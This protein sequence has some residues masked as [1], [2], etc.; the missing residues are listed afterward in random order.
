MSW[1]KQRSAA[2]NKLKKLKKNRKNNVRKNMK[3]NRNSRHTNKGNYASRHAGLKN[4]RLRSRP[5][6][7]PPPPPKKN[8]KTKNNKK[9][10][11]KTVKMSKYQCMG[12]GGNFLSGNSPFGQCQLKGAGT[13]KHRRK[14]RTRRRKRRT[15]RRKRRTK[16]GGN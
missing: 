9:K 2:N 12:T 4:S 15:R 5:T 1:I 6:M 11:N 7:A 16:R 8:N 10:N 14:R 3:N 13:K